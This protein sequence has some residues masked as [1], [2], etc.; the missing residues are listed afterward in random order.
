MFNLI[1][2]YAEFRAAMSSADLKPHEQQLA[3]MT[4]WGLGCPEGAAPAL[5]TV[6]GKA[7]NKMMAIQKTPVTKKCT[8]VD[9]SP[10][11]SG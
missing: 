6:V 3:G 9:V 7:G 8:F 5:Q 11:L 4:M 10:F 1:Q 2:Q